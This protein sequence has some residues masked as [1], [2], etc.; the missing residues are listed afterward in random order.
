MV[1]DISI[2]L[3]SFGLS[4]FTTLFHYATYLHGA[5]RVCT[6]VHSRMLSPPESFRHQTTS[7]SIELGPE[8][9]LIQRICDVTIRSSTVVRS[10]ATGAGAPRDEA[11]LSVFWASLP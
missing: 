6:R 10:F 11:G 3:I 7:A 1:K 2:L 4:S 5:T 8:P 9:T